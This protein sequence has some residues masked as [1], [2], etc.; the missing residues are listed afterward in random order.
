VITSK[1]N[2]KVKYVRSLYRR[3]VRQRERRFV[4]EGVRLIEEMTKAGQAPVFAF[5]SAGISGDARA[6]AV[7]EALRA[8]GAEVEVVSDDVMRAMADTKTPQGILAVAPFPEIE[9]RDVHLSLVLDGLRDPG[10]LGTILRSAEAAGVGQVITMSGTVDVFGPKVVRGAM[11]AHFRLPIR[12]DRSWDEI[13]D[14]LQERQVLLADAGGETAYDRVDWSQPSVL[15]V[16]GEARGAGAEARRLCSGTVSI[17]MRAGV[18]S[19]NVAV[20][21]SIILFEAARQLGA[22]SGKAAE[23]EDTTLAGSGR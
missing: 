4:A 18:D 17:P 12:A 10:N 23:R 19:L 15:I 2:R 7:V 11:G 3:P 20:A 8:S 21:T 9:A 1:T 14:T 5:Y 16:G 13:S 6:E 22:G